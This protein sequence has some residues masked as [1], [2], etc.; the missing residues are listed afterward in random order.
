VKSV[1]DVFDDERLQFFLRNRDDIKTWA[2]LESEVI[3]ATRELL[4]GVQPLIEERA[5]GLDPAAVVG[6][7]D[8]GSWERII[9][10]HQPWPLAVGLTLEWH[11]NVDPL[12][13]YPPKLGVFFWAD[14]SHLVPVRTQFQTSAAGLGLEQLGYKVPLE[15]VWPV[16]ARIT[17]QADWWR[18]PASWVESI[19]N[20]LIPAW[21][22]VAPELDAA[23]GDWSGISDG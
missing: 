16:G 14:P 5:V 6:R 23:L 13:A 21:P 19:I 3:A 9:I 15:G 12:G 2:A 8:S 7:H 10:R 18:S 1:D 22:I 17:G 11:R 4:A 20:R